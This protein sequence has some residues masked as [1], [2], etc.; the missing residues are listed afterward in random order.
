[1]VAV[2]IPNEDD[3]DEQVETW[4]VDQIYEL[5]KLKEK[6]KVLPKALIKET[7][8]E[9]KEKESEFMRNA[10]GNDARLKFQ[11]TGTPTSN[12][13]H[14]VHTYNTRFFQFNVVNYVGRTTMARMKQ[15]RKGD[16]GVVNLE[17]YGVC[18]TNEH[19]SRPVQVVFDIVLISDEIVNDDDNPS[20][21]EKEKHLTPLEES[22]AQSI[23]AANT[24]LREMKYMEKREQRMRKTA[25]SINARVRWFS[26]LSVSVLLAVTYI[27]VTYL[28]RYFHKKKLM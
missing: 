10:G 25:E 19:E 7:P 14:F 28:K 2:T 1:M 21:F 9:I 20:G 6:H 13:T 12:P 26:Y 24:V 18:L 23:E 11:I 22:L 3:T 16:S 15:Y 4:Y 5:T 27:Q 8:S 17:G